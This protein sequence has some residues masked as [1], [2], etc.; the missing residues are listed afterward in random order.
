MPRR[1]R[2]SPVLYHWTPSFHSGQSW[3]MRLGTSSSGSGRCLDPR[4]KASSVPKVCREKIQG[5]RSLRSSQGQ[6]VAAK[7]LRSHTHVHVTKQSRLWY[8]RQ[9]QATRHCQVRCKEKNIAKTAENVNG[10]KQMQVM[11]YSVDRT[12]KTN[13]GSKVNTYQGTCRNVT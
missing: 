4:A 6:G 9:D 2:A 7:T 1:Q 5:A 10:N 11:K 13:L 3:P 8:N 12:A